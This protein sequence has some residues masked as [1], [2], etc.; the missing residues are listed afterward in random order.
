MSFTDF[1]SE[2]LKIALSRASTELL[3]EAAQS[4]YWEGELSGSALSTATALTAGALWL[5]A[6]P[7]E[8]DGPWSE[9]VFIQGF[10][11]LLQDQ[12]LDGGW[13]DTDLR[14]IGRR[15]TVSLCFM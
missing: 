1:N 11:W 9:Q 10:K 8:K 3:V 15:F 5:Q 14:K 12:N 13:G 6:R 2:P 7:E 4:G